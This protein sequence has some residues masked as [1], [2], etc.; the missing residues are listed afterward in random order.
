MH[1]PAC[2]Y[3]GARLIQEIF[4]YRIPAA[5]RTRQAK[6]ALARWLQFGRDE[7]EIRR[8]VKLDTALEPE[9]EKTR[10]R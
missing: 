1:N 5:D 10:R 2:I 8:L 7:A 6:A 9:H 3:C 4:K